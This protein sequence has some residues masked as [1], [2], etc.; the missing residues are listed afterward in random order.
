M[1]LNQ[2]TL[3][4]IDMARSSEFYQKLGLVLIVDSIPRYARFECPDGG[5]TLY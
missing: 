2:L 1:R 5:T 4:S 3:P